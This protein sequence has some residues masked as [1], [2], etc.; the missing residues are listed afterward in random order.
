V[1]TVD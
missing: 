1:N